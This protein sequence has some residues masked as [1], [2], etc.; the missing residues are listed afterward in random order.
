MILAVCHLTYL[1][2][3]FVFSLKEMSITSWFTA[4]AGG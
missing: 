3:T 1:L 2:T 4:A